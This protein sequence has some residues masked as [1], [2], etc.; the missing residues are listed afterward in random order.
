MRFRVEARRLAGVLLAALALVSVG[1]Q[2]QGLGRG[3]P[4]PDRLGRTLDGDAV[5]LA[6]HRG[7]IV[8]VTFWATWC[9]YCLK[10]L[11]QLEGLQNV[12]KERLR[13]IA[14][15]TEDR[16]VFRKVAGLMKDFKLQLVSDSDKTAQKAYGV[17]ALPHLFIIDR[18]GTIA[19]AHRGYGEESLEAILAEVNALL[20]KPAQP[21]GEGTTGSSGPTAP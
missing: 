14:V 1:V 21:A 13:V 16:K 20:A 8:V 18:D 11:P 7:Q 6:G 12:A 4:A 5:T 9:P 3:D 2:A 15:N 19:G 10:E 17:T